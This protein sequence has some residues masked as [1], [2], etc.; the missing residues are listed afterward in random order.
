MLYLP[1]KVVLMVFLRLAQL[2]A[3]LEA[4]KDAGDQAA[5]DAKQAQIEAALEPEKE[6]LVAIREKLS[7]PPVPFQPSEADV[8]QRAAE[9]YGFEAPKFM[10]EQFARDVLGT[11]K[12]KLLH[13]DAIQ[14]AKSSPIDKE[15]MFINRHLFFL[16]TSN[17]LE[18]AKLNNVKR[19]L[20]WQLITQKDKVIQL[21]QEM[22][23]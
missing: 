5:I 6:E 20:T 16:K 4:L 7:K 17:Y 11:D 12:D 10:K 23:S 21:Q 3:D 2:L 18:R 8:R 1:K 22:N 19:L 15:R 14:A 9:K 13:Y